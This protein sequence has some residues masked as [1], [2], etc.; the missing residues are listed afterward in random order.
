MKVANIC[1]GAMEWN[2]EWKYIWN[3][4]NV[5]KVKSKGKGG[6]DLLKH[7][8]E[9]T[10]SGHQI[11][12]ESNWHRIKVVFRCNMI[13]LNIHC[14][15]RRTASEGLWRTS[16][17]IILFKRIYDVSISL[18]IL[19]V[20]VFHQNWFHT[21]A[22]LSFMDIHVFDGILSGNRQSPHA[23][24]RASPTTA[25]IIATFVDTAVFGPDLCVP[26]PGPQGNSGTAKLVTLAALPHHAPWHYEVIQWILMRCH[27]KIL[28]ISL[29]YAFHRISMR[30]CPVTILRYF[31]S[32]LFYQC[33]P[34]FFFIQAIQAVVSHFWKPF[35]CALDRVGI[36]VF[37]CRLIRFP[38]FGRFHRG[39]WH[40]PRSPWR[41]PTCRCH[42]LKNITHIIS[43]NPIHF[44]FNILSY[45]FSHVF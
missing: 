28:Y 26:I 4:M 29:L 14:W 19:P 17:F 27:F 38:R 32:D 3:R 8:E 16:H 41:R 15:Q 23:G 25:R 40:F 13:G 42:S 44:L 31:R 45:C 35:C 21:L 30:L 2:R 34:I 24:S 11:H 5:L 36:S 10:D 1:Y 33:F 12:L 37:Q 20:E 22:T 18:L 9:D 6:A 39:L 43:L 7:V